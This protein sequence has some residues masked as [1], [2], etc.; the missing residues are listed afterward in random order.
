MEQVQLV[1]T[2]IESIWGRRLRRSDIE[3]AIVEHVTTLTDAAHT[4]GD[5]QIADRAI[6]IVRRLVVCEGKNERII[7][8]DRAPTNGGVLL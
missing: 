8:G 6:K 3:R 1:D 2:Y 7:G 5:D 4:V